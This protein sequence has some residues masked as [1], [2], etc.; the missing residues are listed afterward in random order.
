MSDPESVIHNDCARSTCPC[1]ASP[2]FP[3]GKTALT[4]CP[5]GVISNL[6][7]QPD[8]WPGTLYNLGAL[9]TYEGN[10]SEAIKYFDMASDVISQLEFSEYPLNQTIKLARTYAAARLGMP[11]AP[12]EKF[13]LGICDA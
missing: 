3:P 6:G 11:S 12:G 10:F 4:A 2:L 7:R 5:N 13:D 9:R 1:F 8:L